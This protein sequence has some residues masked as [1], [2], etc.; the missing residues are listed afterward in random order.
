MQKMFSNVPEA[1]YNNADGEIENWDERMLI[2]AMMKVI[3]NQNEKINTLED[4][5]NALNERL[6]KLEEMLKGVVK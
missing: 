4:I 1:T 6:N 5:V 3:Q 2:P